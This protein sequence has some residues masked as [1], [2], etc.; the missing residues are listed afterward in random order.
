MNRFN[1]MT[2]TAAVALAISACASANSP[3]TAATERQQLLASGGNVGRQQ[4]VSAAG[5]PFASRGAYC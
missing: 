5:R 3:G 2:Y 1:I 4:Y